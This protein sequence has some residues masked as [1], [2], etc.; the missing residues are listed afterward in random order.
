MAAPIMHPLPRSAGLS[1]PPHRAIFPQSIWPRPDAGRGAPRTH[2]AT[3][4]PRRRVSTYLVP[5]IPAIVGVATFA[6]TDPASSA[7]LPIPL[8]SPLIS[9][10]IAWAISWGM[11]RKAQQ[12]TERQLDKVTDLLTDVRERVSKIEGVLEAQSR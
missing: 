4:Q 7:G 5:L 8:S 9:A 3:P 10:G 1:T 12:T 2:P 11:M 6:A